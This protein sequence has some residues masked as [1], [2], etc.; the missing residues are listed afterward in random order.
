M[1]Y[2]LK[3]PPMKN[4]VLGAFAFIAILTTAVLPA[5]ANPSSP[6]PTATS[7][8]PPT[9]TAFPILPYQ[10]SI[11]IASANTGYAVGSGAAAAIGVTSIT[12]SNQGSTPVQVDIFQASTT[13]PTC[14]G[15]ISNVGG[16]PNIYVMVPATGNLQLTFPTPIIIKHLNSQVCLGF[17][18]ASGLAVGNA[19]SVLVAGFQN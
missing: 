14:T 3:G 6:Q 2:R 12:L 5:R 7:Y 15:S 17:N 18:A 19:I 16:A 9:P 8:G 13:G 1:N 11:Q 10:A 4:A